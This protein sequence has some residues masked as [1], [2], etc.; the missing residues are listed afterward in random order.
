MMCRVSLVVAER[1]RLDV[2]RL[3]AAA[4]RY[5]WN[6][7]WVLQG[8][9]VA[10][11][12][13]MLVEVRGPNGTGK[14]TLLRLLAGAS[15]PSRGARIAAG[16]TVGYAPERLAPPPFT[17]AGYLRHHVRVRSRRRDWHLEAERL[18]AARGGHVRRGANHAPHEREV[19]ELAER[20][21]FAHLL[22]ERMTALSKGSLQKVVLTQALL[23][24]PRL[25]VLDEP[26][27]GLDADAQRALRELIDERRHAGSAVVFTDHREA[28]AGA[29]PDADQ[30]WL[31]EGGTVRATA[32]AP[33]HATSR[34]PRR[35]RLEVARDASDAALTRLLAEGWHVEQVVP[36]GAALAI[37]ATRDA[38]AA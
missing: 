15:L 31:L 10:V 5:R 34:N 7:P 4:K 6:G 29:R 17:A 35:L 28:S 27:S 18:G 19:A 23:G 11:E 25:L 37:E 2:V 21:G 32:V 9:D 30:L 33:E 1:E 13:S 24:A 38:G 26:F 16:T 20:L 3:R 8:V 22:G 14:S 36:C 12:P